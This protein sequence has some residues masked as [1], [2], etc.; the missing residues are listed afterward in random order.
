MLFSDLEAGMS[1]TFDTYSPA[2]LGARFT[3]VKV[4]GI[5]TYNIAE[6]QAPNRDIM[7]SDIYSELPQGTPIDARDLKYL[8]VY[9]SKTETRRVFALNWIKENTITIAENRSI[10]IRINQT[11]GVS[12]EAILENL[13]FLGVS[14]VE[15]T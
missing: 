4:E 9:D 10:T 1:I 6:L 13:L 8:I 12:E 7:H 3:N 14:N 15:I 11:N 5:V 2:L